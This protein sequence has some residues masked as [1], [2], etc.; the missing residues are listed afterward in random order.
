MCPIK[1]F[2]TESAAS[3][4]KGVPTVMAETT[5]HGREIPGATE[6]VRVGTD[7]ELHLSAGANVKCP[8]LKARSYFRASGLKIPHHARAELNTPQG[9]R[10]S[11]PYSAS[12]PEFTGACLGCQV[13]GVLLAGATRGAS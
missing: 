5:L 10:S 4:A 3:T 9:K 11:C 7:I 1:L 6:P 12:S 13:P 2:T 8:R